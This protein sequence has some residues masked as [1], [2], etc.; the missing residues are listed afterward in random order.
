MLLSPVSPNLMPSS[1]DNQGWKYVQPETGVIF[2][3]MALS[4]LMTRVKRHRLAMKIEVPFNFEH[5]F[6]DELCRQQGYACEPNAKAEGY[7]TPLVVEGRRL[8]KEL[9][10]YTLAVPEAPSGEEQQTMREWFDG[11]VSR[12]PIYAG[13]KCQQG[14]AA[15]LAARPAN[16][17]SRAAFFSFGVE[18]HADISEKLGKQRWTVT[19]ASMCGP[20]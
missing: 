5:A 11:W 20:A 3:S 13:C 7:E 4:D 18:L 16:F 1:T 14:L 8:W 9:H 12:C 2:R 19:G 10:E 6:L 17:V 15:A